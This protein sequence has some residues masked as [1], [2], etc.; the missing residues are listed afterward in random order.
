MVDLRLILNTHVDF[1]G[2]VQQSSL[3]LALEDRNCED[4]QPR[5]QFLNVDKSM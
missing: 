3:F 5:V 2:H 1:N 4:A